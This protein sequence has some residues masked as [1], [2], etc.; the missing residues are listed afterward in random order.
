MTAP[1]Y[2]EWRLGGA[3]L[4]AQLQATLTRLDIGATGNAA[5]RLYTTARPDTMGV[6]TAPWL[7]IPLARPAGV[8][9]DGLLVLQPQNAAGVMVLAGG[10][11]RWAELVAADG[12]V[13]AEGGVTAA[14]VGGCFEVAGGTVPDGEV[15]PVFYAGGLVTLTGSALG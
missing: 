11:P 12:A 8:I 6:S 10:I 1:A 9:A 2:D 5:V 13:L 14:G 3:L 15:A 4:L 7:E